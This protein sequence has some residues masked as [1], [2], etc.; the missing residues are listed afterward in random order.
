MD[1]WMIYTGSIVA[2]VAFFNLCNEIAPMLVPISLIGISIALAITVRHYKQWTSG[3]ILLIATALVGAKRWEIGTY[4]T[5][6]AI[7]IVI[8]QKYWKQQHPAHSFQLVVYLSKQRGVQRILSIAHALKLRIIDY[9]QDNNTSP[10]LT[11]HYSASPLMNHLFLRSIISQ[12]SVLRM[13]RQSLT[14]NP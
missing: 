2:A 4:L 11:L 13:S 1:S 3:M 6:T 12:K 8:G 9:T 14:P 5:L 10:T 7:A